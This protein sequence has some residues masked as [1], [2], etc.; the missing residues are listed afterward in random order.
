MFPN[1][2][3]R[4]PLGSVG[5]RD[6]DH[7]SIPQPQ[8]PVLFKRWQDA[9]WP[10]DRWPNFSPV[11]VACRCAHDGRYCAGELYW[12]PAFF[13]AL[14]ALRDDLGRSVRLN[15]AHR[16]D[17]RNAA[18]GGAPLSQHKAMAADIDLDGHHPGRLYRAAVAAGF[19]SFGFY[20]TFL[21]VDQRPGRRWFS[22]GAR[23]LWTEYLT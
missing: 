15:S 21:H 17:L 8:A 4:M 11:E 16:C 23:E 9:P 20:R 14:Q 5:A 18:V 2:L 1:L 13:D 10:R 19:T 6:P 22:Q 12:D 3:G 7:A